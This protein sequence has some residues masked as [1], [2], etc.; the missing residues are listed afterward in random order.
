MEEEEETG[1]NASTLVFDFFFLLLSVSASSSSLRSSWAAFSLLLLVYITISKSKVKKN[2]ATHQRCNFGR[3]YL[4]QHIDNRLRFSRHSVLKS[5]VSIFIHCYRS[6]RS[7]WNCEIYVVVFDSNLCRLKVLFGTN[8]KLGIEC[9]E[10]ITNRNCPDP[11]CI[12]CPLL[13][14]PVEFGCI[15]VLVKTKIDSNL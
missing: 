8:K 4:L 6:G 14:I 7:T 11:G 5:F 2:Y 1:K 9:I 13:Q 3:I 10:G 15:C 12:G